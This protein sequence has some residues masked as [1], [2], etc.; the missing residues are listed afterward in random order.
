MNSQPDV[1]LKRLPIGL[2]TI[3]VAVCSIGT[4]SSVRWSDIFEKRKDV[5]DFLIE[6]ELGERNGK[7]D[8]N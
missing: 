2:T 7:E 5:G 4:V 3:S 6:E 8:F 1:P